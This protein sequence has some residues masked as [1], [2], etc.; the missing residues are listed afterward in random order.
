MLRAMLS[1]HSLLAY[2][3][4]TLGLLLLAPSCGDGEA[5]FS[6]DSK[7]AGT[8]G[9]TG[10]DVCKPSPELC[11]GYGNQRPFRPAEHSAIHA[12]ET[13][14]MIVFGGSQSLPTAS[15]APG[16]SD[17][18]N[19]TW[20]Y[21]EACNAWTEVTAP[22]PDRRSRHVAAYGQG[23]MWLF[24]GRFRAEGT[25]AG[26]YRLFDD[27]WALDVFS[28]TWDELTPEGDL[29]A[30]RSNSAAAWDSKQNRV[31]V[32]GG[33][34]SPGSFSYDLVNDLWSYDPADNRWRQASTQGRAPTPRLWHSM[35]YDAARHRLVV[36][37]GTDAEGATTGVYL[38]DVYA[39][40][41]EAQRWEQL[42]AGD[43]SA[44]DGRFWGSVV[45]RPEQQDYLLFGGHDDTQLGNRNDTYRF[46]PGDRSWTQLFAG[47]AFNRPA[48]DICDFPPDFAD[49]QPD[50]PERRH[51]SSLVWSTACGKAL[52]FGGK[53]DCGVID[54]LW[55][56]ADGEWSELQRA[57]EG[58]V[59]LR[60]REDP[61]DCS[62]LCN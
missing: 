46:D 49:I 40:D 39:F 10:K 28:R 53:T 27:L 60:W 58:E 9:D 50:Q 57:T 4:T 36:F 48:N 21:S 35:L 20:I 54:D 22:G 47:D 11:E 30:A 29:P 8:G 15:C 12:P 33:N 5:N 56:Y 34:R 26:D 32:F 61:N 13:G 37:G 55:S 42:H 6:E 52:L 7:E 19:E 62:N 51:A 44:P 31:W 23:T 3:L 24:G 59:C 14:E 25:Q 2:G 18:T 16:P 41:L 45:Y 1:Q 17:Y 43:G 38:S